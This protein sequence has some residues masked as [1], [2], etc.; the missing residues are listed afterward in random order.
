VLDKART[1]DLYLLTDDRDVPFDDDGLR[2][3]EHLR[4]WMTGRFREILASS[5]APVVEL[6][7]PHDTRLATA[8]EACDALIAKGWDLTS[9]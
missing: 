8:I 7:G 5:G 1:P 2:D 9:P 3:G 4:P 6:H